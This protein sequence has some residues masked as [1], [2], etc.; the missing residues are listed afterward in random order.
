MIIQIY[1][2]KYKLSKSL[3]QKIDVFNWFVNIDEH[4][5]DEDMMSMMR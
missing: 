2:D 4:Y 5:D 3:V 1:N